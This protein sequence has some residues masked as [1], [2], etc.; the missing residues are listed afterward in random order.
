MRIRKSEDGVILSLNKDFYDENAVDSAVK[1]FARICKVSKTEEN[2]YNLIHFR[3]L[4]PGELEEV[5][6]E[7]ANHVLALMKSGWKS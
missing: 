3:E 7:F 4:E 6:M 2:G 5:A 1:D